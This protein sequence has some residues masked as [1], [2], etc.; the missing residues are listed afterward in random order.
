M[1]SISIFFSLFFTLTFLIVQCEKEPDPNDPVDIPDQNF[2][3]ALIEEGVDTNRNGLISYA[4]AKLVTTIYL[5]PDSASSSKGSIRSLE[6]IEAFVNLDTLHFCFNQ[7]SQLDVSNNSELRVLICWNSDE[8]DQLESLNVS[9][10]KKL[11][12]ISIPGNKLTELNVSNCPSLNKLL[13]WYN[14][15]TDLDISRNTNLLW[16]GL[17]GNLLSRL[18]VSNNI[19]LGTTINP[20]LGLSEMPTLTEVCVWTT[21]FPPSGMEVDTAGSPNVY[22]T[23]DCSE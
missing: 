4:E 12:H 2:L 19:K 21:P 15:I 22:F 17:D 3:D 1:K 18:D 8:N 5:D 11:E 13:L 6:G 23:T 16:L 20:A 7:V 10:N 14:Q 9:N